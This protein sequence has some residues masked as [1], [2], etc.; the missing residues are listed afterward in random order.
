MIM[1][2]ELGEIREEDDKQLLRHCLA[3]E[4]SDWKRP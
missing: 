1:K 2:Y 4:Y 3:F